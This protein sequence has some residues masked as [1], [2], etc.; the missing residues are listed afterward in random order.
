MQTQEGVQTQK[1]HLIL[2]RY[3]SCCIDCFD[4]VVY[5]MPPKKPVPP[6]AAPAAKKAPSAPPQRKGPAGSP[7]APAPPA[8]SGKKVMLPSAA[9][10]KS[11]LFAAFEALVQIHPTEA[12]ARLNVSESECTE[13]G[14]I[15][16]AEIEEHLFITEVESRALIEKSEGYEA[17]ELFVLEGTDRNRMMA[18]VLAKRSAAER[19]ASIVDSGLDPRTLRRKSRM[20]A[21]LAA[22]EIRLTR[23]LSTVP[24]GAKKAIS[25]DRD[26]WLAD[27]DDVKKQLE[28]AK[29]EEDMFCM[30]YKEGRKL[31]AKKTADQRKELQDKRMALEQRLK[32]LEQM[33]ER[34]RQR[35]VQERE[36]LRR[37][38]S[39]QVDRE[40]IAGNKSILQKAADLEIKRIQEEQNDILDEGLYRKLVMEQG[41]QFY[42]ELKEHES[43]VKKQ[44]QELKA[45]HGPAPP[46]PAPPKRA[47]SRVALKSKQEAQVVAASPRREGDA[48]GETKLSLP[49]IRHQGQP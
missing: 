39:L 31:E 47:G 35:E 20:D 18:A 32:K 38:G 21:E 26:K 42:D 25:A 2:V 19:K 11:A 8:K 4:T 34:F 7:R 17:A 23:E 48:T 46:P 15:M 27:M 28:V 24:E 6:A 41:D 22:E 5:F 33:E 49:S 44:T 9:A 13:Y 37:C 29:C 43:F 14:D 12:K 36:R 10:Q 30:K 1:P 45:L 16:K 3:C 40:V